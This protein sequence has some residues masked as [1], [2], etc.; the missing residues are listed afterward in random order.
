VVA[1]T[2]VPRR[3]EDLVK[4]ALSDTRV[5]VVNGAR[6]VG[7]S[8]LI[9]AVT[10]GD[11]TVAERRLDRTADREA[12]RSDPERFV[13]HD[14]LLVI[15]EVQ[16]AP[17]LVL[18][19]KARVDEDNRP[20]QFLL[21]GSARLLGL[22]GLPDALVGRTETIELWPFS[23]GEIEGTREAFIDAVFGEAKL[24]GAS[25]DSASA[26]GRDDYLERALAGGYP[27]AVSREAARRRKFFDAYVN[28]L[29]DRDVMQLSEIQRRPELHRLLGQLGARMASPLKVETISSDL[30][31]PKSTA[32]RYVA[33]LEEVFLVKRIPAWANSAATRAVKM[34]K[35]MFVDTALGANVAGITI[36]R[37]RRDESLA[38]QIIE[39]FVTGEIGRQRTWADL[40]VQMF[41]YRD[42]EQRE[43]DIV[44]EAN[45]GRVVGLEVKSSTTAR[46]EDFR[47]LEHLRRLAGKNFHHGYVLY[48]GER[49]LPFGDRL[50]AIPVCNLWANRPGGAR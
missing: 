23:Q 46:A 25:N 16:R 6:Q 1:T 34:S 12:A 31:L 28:D 18:S 27:E 29:I 49:A 11:D 3:A 20:G 41:H 15:D 4:V 9:R 19:I 30:A 17:D 22:R 2:H 43:V 14:G 48:T 5:V 26:V 40:S 39:N 33:L 36:D 47:H 10:R 13:A 38:G 44:L 50:T 35:L 24:V 7:K 45:D 42:R 21:T 37:V 32:E 8:T